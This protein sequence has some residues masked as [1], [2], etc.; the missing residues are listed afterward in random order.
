MKDDAWQ[1]IPGASGY[2]LP[3]EVEWEYACGAGTTSNFSSGSDEQMLEGYARLRSSTAVACGDKLAN[4]WGLF[5]MHGNVW[6]WCWD[7]DKQQDANRVLR[8]GSWNDDAAYC[9][10]AIRLTGTPAY[11]GTSIGLRLA[12]SSS[13]QVPAEPVQAKASVGTEGV[14]E[15]RP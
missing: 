4:G 5:D 3:L 11:R 9:R 7:L 10:T 1:L 14:A 8:G 15:Q 13:V 2:R 6:E 12:L